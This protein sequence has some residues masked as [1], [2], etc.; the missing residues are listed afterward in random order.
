MTISENG[1]FNAVNFFQND[2]ARI[3]FTFDSVEV[4]LTAF[5]SLVM[6]VRTGQRLNTP[7]VKRL[8]SGEGITIEAARSF[9]ANLTTTQSGVFYAALIGEVGTN[10]AR[11]LARG[12]IIVTAQIA[13]L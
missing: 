8:V 13:K 10:L 5:T 2:D 3:I 11:T 12:K 7:L 1:S 6:E 4:D 9:T